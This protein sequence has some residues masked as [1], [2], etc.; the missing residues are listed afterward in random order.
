M[1][2]VVQR[3]S[4]A[5]VTVDGKTVSSVGKGLLVLAGL[6]KDDEKRDM[7][8]I[9]K[10][11]TELRLFEDDEQ[12]MNLSVKD[13]DGEL[14]IVSQFTL[15]GNVHK[16]RRPSFDNAMKPEK[17][18]RMF[19]EFVQDLSKVHPKVKTGVFAA[20]MDVVLINDGP[21]TFTIDSR[22]RV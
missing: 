6:E 8:Y 1:I 3:V 10:K 15:S 7:D 5:S 21:V 14:L 17:A 20:K 18:E 22:K 9:I 19:E 16:G 12:K 4:Q 13:I 2:A 11:I